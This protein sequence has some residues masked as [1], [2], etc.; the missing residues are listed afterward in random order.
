MPVPI[1]LVGEGPESIKMGENIVLQTLSEVQVEA[2]PADLIENIEVN[3]DVL[4]N[5]DDAITVGQL[6]IDRDKLTL[7]A[8]A[9][10]V[11]V[12]LAP[13]VTEE[14]KQLLNEQEAESQAIVE[15]SSEE[16]ALEGTET[17]TDAEA[18][19]DSEKASES[20]EETNS[21]QE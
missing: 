7:L 5:V 16:A 9:D 3:I 12:K 6:L 17:S 20:T 1:V 2:L 19:P 21:T 4:K 15:E 10:D 13:A 8:D 14:M 11:V 18:G